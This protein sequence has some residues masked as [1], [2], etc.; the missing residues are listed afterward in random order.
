MTRGAIMACLVF[1]VALTLRFPGLD[2]WPPAIHQD[3]ASNVVDGWSLQSDGVDRAGRAWPVFLEGFGAGDNR[4]SLYAVLTIPGVALFGPGAFAARLPAALVGAWTVLALFLFTRRVRGEGAAFWAAALLAANP[5][6]IY[7]S[8]FGHEASITPAFLVT[9]LL[10]VAGTEVIAAPPK[11]RRLILRWGVAGLVLAAGLYSYPSFRLFLPLV[12]AAAWIFKAGPSRD[13]A[14]LALPA[15]LVIGA[16]PLL[17]ASLAHPDRL[18]GRASATLI[19][20]NVEP[21]PRAVWLAVQQYARHFLPGFLFVRGDANPL[22]SPPGGEL[23]WVELPALIVGLVFMARR[24]DSWDR[25]SLVWLLLYPVASAI[26]LGD[27]PEYVPHALRAAVGLPLFQFI[28]GDG[29]A[30]ALASISRRKNGSVATSGRGAALAGSLV[31]IAIAVNLLLVAVP[32]TRSYARAV[33]PRYHAAYP[34]AVRYL[35]AHGN[36]Y[37]ALVISGRGV[38]QAYIY[39]I[40]YGLQTPRA[41]REEP[42]DISETGFFHVVHRTGE[43]YYFYDSEDLL[44]IRSLVHGR[45][46]ILAAPGEIRAGSVIASFPYADGE[47]GLEVRE[48]A[49]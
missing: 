41:F 44:R 46:W 7:L 15:A 8:R 39:S 35:A 19:F 26:T 20:G 34:P 21:L 28:G 4:T 18:L 10:L 37:S 9:A 23:L 6:H 38:Q 16:L 25:L 17:G 42:K 2:R 22:Q 14:S 24:R 43:I 45:V 36:S 30:T 11:P 27:R 12:L 13:R 29:I 5:W 32:F 47:P 31:A 33:A 40:L 48:I 49:I 1:L 3:E